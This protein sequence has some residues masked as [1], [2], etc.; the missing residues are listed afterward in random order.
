MGLFK[1]REERR[2]EREMAA[3][4]ALANFRRQIQQQEKHEK[5][6]L[7]KAIRAKQIGDQR[8]LGTLKAQIRR[9]HAIKYR[10]ERAMLMLEVAMQ[11]KD[12]VESFE[13]FG[14]GMNALSKS[15]QQAYG[16]TDRVRT[17][18]DYEMAMSKASNM[19]QRI[20]LFLE[21]SFDAQGDVSDEELEGV[22]MTDQDLDR[23]LDEGAARS[24]KTGVD[25]EIDQSLADIEKEL[26]K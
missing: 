12:Q 7:Q 2:I 14:K 5:G 23:L 3:R 26:G 22:G 19:E 17:Q 10:F 21:S 25:S 15:I 16:V 4:K 6:Y 18:R 11:A 20:D 1:S 8:M 24:E 13:S 9:T